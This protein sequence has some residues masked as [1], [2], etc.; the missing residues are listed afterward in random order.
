MNLLSRISILTIIFSSTYSTLYSQYA[1][2]PGEVLPE[3]VLRAP[4]KAPLRDGIDTIPTFLD[5]SLSPYFPEIINQHGGSCAQAAA[6]HYVFT[7]EMNR[8]LEREV[9]SNP[10]GNTFSYRWTWNFL[11]DGAD[12]G[13]ISTDGLR[14]AKD[15]GCITVAD[16]G[17]EDESIFR[18]VTGYSKYYK[19]MHYR[20][21]NMYYVDL[22]TREGIDKLIQYMI[23]KGDGHPGGGIAVFSLSND[24]DVGPYYGPSAVGIEDIIVKKGSHGGHAMT[25]VGYDLTVEYDCDKDGKIDDDEKGAFIFV[26]NWGKWWGSGGKAYMPFSGFTRPYNN[27]GFYVYNADVIC[28]DTEYQEP[29][30]T[31]QVNLTY[32]SRNDLSIRYGVAEGAQSEYPPY[33]VGSV[34]LSYPIFIGQG[35]DFNMQGTSFES[36]KTIEFGADIS[37][38]KANADK[39]KSPCFFLMISN[40]KNEK[41]GSGKVNS[42]IVHDYSTGEDIKITKAFSASNSVI[43]SG[44]NYYK[45]PSNSLFMNK[46]KQWYE[47]VKTSGNAQ[48]QSANYYNEIDWKKPFAV[49]KANGGYAKV[50]AKSYDANSHKLILDISHYE[51]K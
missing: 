5:N 29:S 37:E 2:H 39:M 43:K 38:L 3:L 36:G 30:L 46:K 20:V 47:P 44:S 50:K 34:I 19:A 27:G 18:W 42:V 4:S 51:F 28:I 7:Y 49:K 22:K 31:M 13:S 33:Y 25:L 6:I 11:N 21:S 8:V 24:W 48:A 26:N 1:M 32:S 17:D 35:G 23:D 14:I 40:V 45:I 12:N 9:A 41:Q 10:K 15:A 16:Y